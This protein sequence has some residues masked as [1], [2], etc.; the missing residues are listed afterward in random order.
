MV[1]KKT[2]DVQCFTEVMTIISGHSHGPGVSLDGQC[3]T[4]I[5]TWQGVE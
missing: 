5:I 1:L 4:E 2:L 3:F